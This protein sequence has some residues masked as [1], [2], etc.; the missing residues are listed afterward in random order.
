MYHYIIRGILAGRATGA[1]SRNLAALRAHLPEWAIASIITTITIIT[2]TIA[3]TITIYITITITM[4]SII[5]S[6]SRSIASIISIISIIIII[7]I[8]IHGPGGEAAVERRGPPRSLSIGI[9]TIISI[10]IIIICIM[11]YHSS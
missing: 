6:N 11:N 8:I 3:I 1:K 4:I 9:S 10:I 7:I 2:I 5:I